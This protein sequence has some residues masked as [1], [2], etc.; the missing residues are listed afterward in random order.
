MTSRLLEKVDANKH[1]AMSSLEANC[2][3]RLLEK[4]EANKHT[5][6]SSLLV[7]A[8]SDKSTFIESRGE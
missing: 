3:K 8:N 5:D 2:D 6:M 7:E 4:V 1:T